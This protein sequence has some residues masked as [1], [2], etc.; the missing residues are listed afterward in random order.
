M[1]SDKKRKNGV[2]ELVFLLNIKIVKFTPHFVRITLSELS[3]LLSELSPLIW[4][5]RGKINQT[6]IWCFSRNYCRK[7]DK[8]DNF[9]SYVYLKILAHELHITLK[10][11]TFH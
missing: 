8:T 11:Y 3:P 10:I 9:L 2:I 5:S 6:Q 7:Y 1:L 4:Q